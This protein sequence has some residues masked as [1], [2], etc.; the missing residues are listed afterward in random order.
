MGQVRPGL[1][2]EPWAASCSSR[3]CI[4]A[5]A[6]IDNHLPAK[7]PD[8]VNRMGSV[9]FNSTPPPPPHQRK[10]S[11]CRTAIPETGGLSFCDAHRLEY[12]ERQRNGVATKDLDTRWHDRLSTWPERPPALNEEPHSE[13]FRFT[14]GAEP[15]I[16]FTRGYPHRLPDWIAVDIPTDQVRR[17]VEINRSDLLDDLEGK[18]P[19]PYQEDLHL[20]WGDPAAREPQGVFSYRHKETG[21]DHSL[22]AMIKYAQIPVYG[23][24]ENPF[25]L[26][27]C[28]T[29]YSF[30]SR[31]LDGVT[32]I[33]VSPGPVHPQVVASFDALRVGIRTLKL[34]P[35]YGSD[36]DS[37]Q[38]LRL[39]R[40]YRRDL[41]D[42]IE[43]V[44]PVTNTCHIALPGFQRDTEVL[45]WPEPV[46]LL[47]FALKNDEIYLGVSAIGLSEPE[48]LQLL[49]NVQVVNNQPDLLEQYQAELGQMRD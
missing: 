34:P 33:F 17:F 38:A 49:R 32:L 6:K 31:G 21:G 30:E 22:P 41:M 1:V 27:L 24:S 48:L 19:A 2:G 29:R 11:V 25:G 40:G 8:G 42:R 47:N 28:T 20:R 7:S 44:S 46:N 36:P 45:S 18:R 35:G 15:W 26:R 43:T 16:L 23:V 37:E 10:C 9:S 13:R 3:R 39:L 5:F 12:D 14:R 4:L